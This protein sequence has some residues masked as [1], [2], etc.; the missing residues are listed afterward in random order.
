MKEKETSKLYNSITNVNNQFIEEAQT[1]KKNKNNWIKWVVTAAACLTLICVVAINYLPHT[2]DD[3]VTTPGVADAPPM[4]CVNGKLYKQSIEQVSYDEIK[5]EFIYLGKI[6]SDVTNSQTASTNGVPKENFQANHPIVGAEVYQYNVDIVIQINGK[7]WLY[8]VL[9]N[10][11]SN[12][13]Q[14][15]LSEEEKK[16]LDPSYKAN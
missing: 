10:E 9:D 14:N 15:E 8:E 7:Y 5:S 6:E 2:E 4:V 12:E 11:N 1:T 13:T 3:I 16:Q